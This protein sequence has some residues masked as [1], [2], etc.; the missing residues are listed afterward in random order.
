MMRP[1]IFS[2]VLCSLGALSL[3]APAHHDKIIVDEPPDEFNEDWVPGDESTSPFHRQRFGDTYL[4]RI[5][6]GQIFTVASE[7][8][9][10]FDALDW[11]E[12]EAQQQKILNQLQRFRGAIRVAL[13]TPGIEGPLDLKA[14]Q[15]IFIEELN[16]QEFGL[17]SLTI[18]TIA[19]DSGEDVSGY[20]RDTSDEILLYEWAEDGDKVRLLLTTEQVRQWRLL[21]NALLNLI[22]DQVGLVSA[23]NI[24]ELKNAVERWENVLDKGYSMMP[25]ESYLNGR[26]IDLP[27]RDFGPPDHQWIVLHPTLGL[28]LSIDDLGESRVKETLHIEAIGHIWYRGRQLQD[29]AGISGTISFREDLDPGIGVL[30]HF[31]RNWSL[32]LTWHDVDEDPFLFFS[33]DLF[34]FAKQEIPK[35]VERYNG[36]KAMIKE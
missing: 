10:L 5:E 19:D 22:N 31:K 28:E 6:N 15:N 30:V 18:E 9:S 25:W 7:M 4:E 13:E 24:M 16:K 21:E 3:S 1:R 12:H 2:L 27:K 29:Y 35:Y 17:H 33:V 23:A 14:E 20:F 8:I 36:V 11:G 34:N 26:W 32:G